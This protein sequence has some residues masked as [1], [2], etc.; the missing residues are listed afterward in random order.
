LWH[1]KK[2]IMK[3]TLIFFV[4]ISMALPVGSCK[5]HAAFEGRITSSDDNQPI[6]DAKVTLGFIRGKKGGGIEITSNMTTYSDATGAYAVEA[7]DSRG[8][9]GELFAEKDG[10]ATMKAVRVEPGDCDEIN[11]VLNP[12]DAW[13]NVTFENTTPGIVEYFYSYSGAYLG[14]HSYCISGCGPHLLQ[15]HEMK[16]EVAVIPGGADIYVNWKLNE[17]GS[18]QMKETIFCARGDTTHLHIKI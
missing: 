3:N 1:E 9:Y 10:F 7:D 18:T 6:T 16:T 4:L 12:Y 13:L 8:E 14:D 11:L 2:I 15:P 5:K 17:N